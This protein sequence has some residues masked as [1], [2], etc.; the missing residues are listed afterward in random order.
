MD[1]LFEFKAR[2]IDGWDD[3]SDLVVQV[4]W[5]R[6]YNDNP[7]ANISKSLPI[8][9]MLKQEADDVIVILEPNHGRHYEESLDEILR[10]LDPLLEVLD[11]EREGVFVSFGDAGE[12]PLA[13]T[14]WNERGMLTPKEQEVD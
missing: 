2:L 3:F 1:I 5:D 8:A 4:E 10:G 14:Y 6:Y 13:A 9:R 7:G 12:Y 11:V